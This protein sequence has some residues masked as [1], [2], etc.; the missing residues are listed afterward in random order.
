MRNF[1]ATLSLGAILLAAGTSAS[2]FA[3]EQQQPAATGPQA[4]APGQTGHV[5]NPQRQARRMAKKLGLSADQESKLEPIL[6]DRDQQMQSAR[7]D[8]TLAP[9]DK[10]AKMRSISQASDAN[11]EGIMNDTQK[12]QYEQMKQ[13]RKAARQ[14][15]GAPS[16]N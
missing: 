2:L 9:K 13:E 1:S 7:A 8:T 11:I 5:A 14:Q 3:Q 16:G 4:A 15:G 10:R 12:Q 6:A